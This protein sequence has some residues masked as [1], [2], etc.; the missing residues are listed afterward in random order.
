MLFS[1]ESNPHILN[2]RTHRVRRGVKEQLHK[3]CVVQQVKHP[4][5]VLLWGAISIHGVNR[6]RIVEGTMRHDQYQNVLKIRL[7]P[8]IRASE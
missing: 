2:D 7:L 6:L 8:Q 1:D 5:Y 3:D 4:L